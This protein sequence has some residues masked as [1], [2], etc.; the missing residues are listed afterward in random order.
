MRISDWSSDVCS[1]DLP[2][3]IT[4]VESEAIGTVGVGEATVPPIHEFNRYLRLDPAEFLRATHGTIKLGIEFEGWGGA[5]H[6]YFHPFGYLG[7]EMSGIHFHHHWLRH[8]A[9]GGDADHGPYNPETMAAREG[10]FAPAPRHRSEERR[11]GKKCVRG[12]L[13][14]RAV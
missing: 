3:G 7:I 8:L 12:E 4:L 11:L 1:S 5:D 6:R 14:G 13:G 9:A 10:R 2:H